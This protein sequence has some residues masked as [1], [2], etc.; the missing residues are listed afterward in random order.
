MATDIKSHEKTFVAINFFSCWPGARGPGA[1]GPGP[2]MA[3]ATAWARGPGPGARG[4]G[5]G[6]GPPNMFAII[7][8]VYRNHITKLRY[9]TND[10]TA[11][12]KC[13]E[14]SP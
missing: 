12:F 4:R 9:G 13:K 14:T 2:G 11:T 10:E 1:R 3:R 6:P 8:R 5:P 7:L